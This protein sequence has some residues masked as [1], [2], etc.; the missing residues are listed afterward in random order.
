MIRSEIQTKTNFD[1]KTPLFEKFLI[2]GCE[3]EDMKEFDADLNCTEA[4]LP[5]KVL[6][7]Y[8]PF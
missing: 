3:K 5:G 1:I 7:A 2:L 8:P 4:L 6:Y